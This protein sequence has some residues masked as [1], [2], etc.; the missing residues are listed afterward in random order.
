MSEQ[1]A[2]TTEQFAAWK[3][4]AAVLELLPTALNSTLQKATGQPLVSLYAL[5]HLQRQPNKTTGLS[6]L[7]ACVSSALPRASRIVARLEA[8][9]L[10][11]RSTCAIDGRAVIVTLTAKGED[12]LAEAMPHHDRLVRDLLVDVLSAEQLEQLRTIAGALEAQLHPDIAAPV[13]RQR[14]LDTV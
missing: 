8:D 11:T 1:A 4:F 12:L 5:G 14:Q 13:D 2:L 3:P 7:A 10:V 6:D 9:G